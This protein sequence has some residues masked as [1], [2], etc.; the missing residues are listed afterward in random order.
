MDWGGNVNT[1]KPM[2][3]ASLRCVSCKICGTLA[4]Q[5][6]LETLYAV[7]VAECTRCAEVRVYCVSATLTLCGGEEEEDGELGS[8]LED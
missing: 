5:I 8:S 7:G 6:N 1:L 3:R 2:E 4:Q